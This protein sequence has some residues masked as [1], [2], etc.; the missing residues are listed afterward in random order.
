[1]PFFR[2]IRIVGTNRYEHLDNICYV[3]FHVMSETLLKDILFNHIPFPIS[4]TPSLLT[5]SVVLNLVLL[6]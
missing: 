4:S 2:N 1:M 6:F 5:V 3:D